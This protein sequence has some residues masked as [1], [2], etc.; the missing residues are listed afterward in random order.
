MELDMLCERK[1]KV[2]IDFMFLAE[3]MFSL[4]DKIIRECLLYNNCLCAY[5]IRDYLNCTNK[6]PKYSGSCKKLAYLS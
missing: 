4:R 5:C 1:W 3:I 2:K 6:A